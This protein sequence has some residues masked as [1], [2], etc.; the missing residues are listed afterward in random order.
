MLILEFSST[1][2]A[3]F[4]NIIITFV[5][6]YNTLALRVIILHITYHQNIE[7]LC[8]FSKIKSY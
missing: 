4:Y 3:H 5:K 2:I 1:R 7:I 8:L 6:I